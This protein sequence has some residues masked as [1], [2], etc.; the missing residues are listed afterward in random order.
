MIFFLVLWVARRETRDL[1][2]VSFVGCGASVRASQKRGLIRPPL[3]TRWSSELLLHRQRL[4]DYQTRT[5]CSRC[6]VE[7]SARK[8]LQPISAVRIYQSLIIWSLMMFHFGH[9]HRRMPRCTPNITKVVKL[10]FLRYN[11]VYKILVSLSR[12]YRD[13]TFL[14]HSTNEVS[15][16]G[17]WI[18]RL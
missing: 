10:Y 1:W 16:D 8:M 5:D 7:R 15:C 17:I 6:R 18:T 14:P 3:V 4:G 12:P 2:L 11:E 13:L 9:W